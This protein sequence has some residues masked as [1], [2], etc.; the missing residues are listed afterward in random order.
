MQIEQKERELIINSC[1]NMKDYLIN[2]LLKNANTD[3][4]PL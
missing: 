3:I 1:E 4:K 2:T